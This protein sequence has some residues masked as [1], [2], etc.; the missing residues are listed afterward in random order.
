MTGH[1]AKKLKNPNHAGIVR[2]LVRSATVERKQRSGRV[3]LTNGRD[4][5]FA[6]VPLPDSNALFTMLDVTD[7]RKIETALRERN[8]ALEDADRL[9]TAFVSNMSYE[10]RT[11]L[12]SIAGFAEMLAGGYAGE[13]GGTADEYVNAIMEAV[14]DRKSGV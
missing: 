14:A 3:S 11:P 9:K 12:T 8:E 7:S 13:L 4:F 10:L 1:I 5:E 6:A 2:E